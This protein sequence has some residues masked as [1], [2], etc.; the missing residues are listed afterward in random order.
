MRTARL[1]RCK[2]AVMPHRIFKPLVRLAALGA[3]V[4]AAGCAAS[5]A[6]KVAACPTLPS[7]RLSARPEP[8]PPVSAQ[9]LTLQPGHW[10]WADGNYVWTQPEWVPRHDAGVPIWQ[11]GFWTPDGGACV[12]NPGHFVAGHG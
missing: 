10:D 11:D 7:K 12:W 5:P 2:L 3:A 9:P 8:L 4:L 1:L 6:P